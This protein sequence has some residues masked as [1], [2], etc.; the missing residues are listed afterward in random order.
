MKSVNQIID[1]HTIELTFEAP[2]PTFEVELATGVYFVSPTA[3][4]NAG[5]TQE[6]RIDWARGN[7]VGTGPFKFVE[8]VLGSHVTYERFDDYWGGWEDNHITK[9]F[10]WRSRE[11]AVHKMMLEK[12]DVDFAGVIALEDWAALDATPEIDVYVPPE[13]IWTLIFTVATTVSP[14]DD[15]HIRRAIKH[16]IDYEAIREIAAGYG[17]IPRGLVPPAVPGHNPNIPEFK[18]DLE[19]VLEKL[20]LKKWFDVVVGIDS[21]NSAKPAKEIFLHALTKIGVQPH[22]A[23]F[24]GDSVETDYKGAMNVGIK[25]FL[26]DREGKIP[27]PYNKIT[28]LTELLTI[29]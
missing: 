16:A 11:P 5:D 22:E 3:F 12:G 29:V 10:Y 4:M 20:R 13:K 8:A 27:S 18:K 24:I 7:P 1:D 17:D 2:Q 28:S 21:C 15:V 6:E 9:A 23:L 25:P 26:I 19:H 14:T